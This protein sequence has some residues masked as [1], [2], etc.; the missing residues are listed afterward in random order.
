[1]SRDPDVS[2]WLDEL[3]PPE[4]RPGFWDDVRDGLAPAEVSTW[5]RRV[6]RAALVAVAS[7]LVG[8]VMAIGVLTGES[9]PAQVTTDPG[10]DTP[11]SPELAEPPEADGARIERGSGVP[12]AVD[13]AGRFLYLSDEAIEGGSGC[14]GGD[15]AAIFVE[16]V[17]GGER[18]QVLPAAVLG[19]GGRFDLRFDDAGRVAA[20]SLCEG[21][22]A[23]IVLATIA[24]DGTFENE[25]EVTVRD[26]DL[27]REVD[28]VVDFEW[29]DPDELVVVT[30][31]QSASGE[32]RHAYSVAVDTG[33]V[34]DLGIDDV[35][36]V[37]VR[38]D[39]TITVLTSDRDVL[40]GRDTV[41]TVPG[42]TE[43]RMTPSG[44]ELV[45]DGAHPNGLTVIDV[46]TGAS[47]SFDVGGATDVVALDDGLVAYAIGEGGG[48]GGRFMVHAG[49]RIRRAFV[50]RG[51]HPSLVVTPDLARVFFVG[52]ANTSPSTSV[53]FEQPLTR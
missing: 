10:P 9:D 49:S 4:H 25:S 32:H 30:S 23:T 29:R 47:R 19:G 28:G 48:Y 53:L 2:R 36:Q 5:R 22:G 51:P 52:H 16:P 20:R 46:D 33:D 14:E 44:R 41:A 3:G 24:E 31:T 26:L 1:M 50:T 45:L 12:I 21:S 34:A 6:P 15:N 39:G 11:A 13:P 40:I 8:A 35:M 17:A 7:A 38:P 43:L 27:D 37:E 18:R 42:A